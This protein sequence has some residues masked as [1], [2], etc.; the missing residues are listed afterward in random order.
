LFFALNSVNN[1]LYYIVF[2]VLGF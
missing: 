1:T 2:L